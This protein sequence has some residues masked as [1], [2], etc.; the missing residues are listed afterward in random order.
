MVRYRTAHP[1]RV[2]AAQVKYRKE[3]IV[4]VR[5]K[6]A[7][8][9]AASRKADPEKARDAVRRA[10]HKALGIPIPSRPRPA[11]CDL[12]GKPPG[13]RSLHVD[14]CHISG[15]FRGWLCSSCNAGIGM[16]GDSIEGLMNAV[17]YLERAAK[18]QEI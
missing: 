13:K 1:E 10:Q 3:N 17:R 6:N 7:I 12:C 2:R 18:Q 8:R 5:A 4:E 9:C 14:H 11:V 16:L 15:I